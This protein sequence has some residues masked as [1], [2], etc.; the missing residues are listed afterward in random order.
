M[1]PPLPPA[2]VVPPPPADI[3]PAELSPLALPVPALVVE[4]T[5][6]AL[7]FVPPVLLAPPAPGDAVVGESEPHAALL[8]PSAMQPTHFRKE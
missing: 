2:G 8:N 4:V 6:P 3:A 1:L 7:P 5:E